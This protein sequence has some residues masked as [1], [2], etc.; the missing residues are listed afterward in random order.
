MTLL[1]PTSHLPPI[2]RIGTYPPG[3]LSDAL[4]FLRLIYNPEVRGSRRYNPCVRADPR[5]SSQNSQ[6]SELDDL[7]SDAFERSYAIKWLMALISQVESWKGAMDGEDTSSASHEREREF[8]VQDAAALLAICSGTAAAGVIVRDFIFLTNRERREALKVNLTDVPLDNQDYGSV[9]AQTWGGAC[10]LAEDI[11]EHPQRFGFSNHQ[12]KNLRI[13]ELGAGTGLVS[14]VVGKLFESMA[15]HPP[16]TVIATDYYP[17]VLTNLEANVRSNFP[18]SDA[19]E[20]SNHVNI[21]THSLDWSSFPDELDHNYP[22]D[23]PFDVILGADI[24]YEEQH[25]V[26]IK[27]CLHQLLRKPDRAGPAPAFH[28]VIPLRRTHASES[29]TIETVFP[30]QESAKSTLGIL[31]KETILCEAGNGLGTGHIEYACY[32]IGWC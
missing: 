14:L 15:E 32:I 6:D 16:V 13:L 22:F 4:K 5:G 1:S 12:H 10:V 18:S 20:A 21:S 11:A 17:S 9:G 19:P 24:I 7:R 26:W 29:S 27:S 25:A 8:L 3:D 23:E 28:L 31:S 2:Q 30:K